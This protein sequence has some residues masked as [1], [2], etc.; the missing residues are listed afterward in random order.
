MFSVSDEDL[1]CPVCHDIF[2]DPVVLSCSHSFCKACLQ[3][4]WREK[5]TCECPCCKTISPKRDPPRNLALK[6]LCEVIL[7]ER[8]RRGSTGSETLCSLH[9]E[10]LRL[11]CLD[12]K[13]AV[14][15]ICRDSKRH[16]NHTFRPIDEA[17]HDQRE[18]LRKF[19]KPFQ[20]KLQLY[21]QVRGNCD[22]TATHVKAQAQQTEKLIKEHFKKFHQF[23]KEEEKARLSALREEEEQKSQI[24]QEKIGALS[25]EIVALSHTIAKTEKELKTEDASFLLNYKAAVARVQQRPLLDDPQLISGAL[26]DVAKHLGNLTFHIWNKMKEIVSYIP[27]ILDPNTADPELVV[28][29]DLSCVR[30]ANCQ[31]LPKNPERTKFSCCVLGSQGFN[32]GSHSWDVDVGDNKDWELGVLGEYIQMN[33][34]LQSGLWRILFSN[35]KLSAFSTSGSEQDVSL[36]KKLQKI[37]VRLDFDRGKLSFFDLDTNTLIHT[38]K[39]TFTD[40]LFP[41]IY[42]E[43]RLSLKIL[44]VKVSVTV[45]TQILF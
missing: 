19:L 37:R 33:E 5:Q 11:F 17:A 38:F 39:H 42:T 34:R 41:Y 35:R 3:K 36:R 31:Q 7:Q 44:P 45:E 30:S 24:V 29:E 9:S 27:V 28:S 26:I 16:T 22:Q 18:E 13:E 21:K 25:K 12:H 32:S 43:N 2:Q 10:K 40:T 6:N 8:D 4:W 15:L 14:C 20:E 1:S 23:L